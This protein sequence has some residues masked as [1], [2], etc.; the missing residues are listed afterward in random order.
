MYKRL[1]EASDFMGIFHR[2]VLDICG[3]RNMEMGYH[4]GDF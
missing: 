4:T 3:T 1:P 2:D